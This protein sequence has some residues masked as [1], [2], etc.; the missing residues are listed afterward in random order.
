MSGSSD[1]EPTITD[2]EVVPELCVN[3]RNC[4]RMAPGAFIPDPK[5]NVTRPALWQRVEPAKLWAAA[6]SCPS[7]A[8]RFVTERGTVVPRWQEAAGWDTTKHPAA[9][10]PREGGSSG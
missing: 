8:I 4:I 6:R 7:G 1:A 3:F 9:A 2:V 10:R 5:R